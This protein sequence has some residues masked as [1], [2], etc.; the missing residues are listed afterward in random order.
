MRRYDWNRRVEPLGQGTFVAAAVV[1][2]AHPLIVTGVPAPPLVP[3]LLGFLMV[4][5]LACLAAPLW[6]RGPDAAL[7]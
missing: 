6:R 4:L 7:S 5:N 1:A 3:L 2:C